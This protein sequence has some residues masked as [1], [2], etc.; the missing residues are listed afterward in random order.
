MQGTRAVTASQNLWPESLVKLSVPLIIRSLEWMHPCE[1]W[2]IY[3]VLKHHDVS[4]AVV[5]VQAAGRVGG[6]EGL[7]AAQLHHTHRHGHLENI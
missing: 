5:A 3:M 6:H 2:D 1:S 4:G 7:D